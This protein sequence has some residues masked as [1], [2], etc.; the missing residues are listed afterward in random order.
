MSEADLV[1]KPTSGSRNESTG[2][3]VSSIASRG[4]RDPASLTKAEIRKIS[5]SALTQKEPSKSPGKKK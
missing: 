4:L 1:K 3:S 5:A 2:N